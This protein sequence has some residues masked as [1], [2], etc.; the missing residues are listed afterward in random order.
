[1]AFLLERE[2]G[3]DGFAAMLVMETFQPIS[4]RWNEYWLVVL[5]GMS[6]IVAS[7]VVRDLRQTERG[8]AR[9]RRTKNS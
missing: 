2:F 4:H 6:L 5:I 3:V 7:D 1:M 9:L 8:L